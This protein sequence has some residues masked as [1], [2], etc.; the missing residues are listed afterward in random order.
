MN[1]MQRSVRR[2]P[3]R[4]RFAYL[5]QQP[6][7]LNLLWIIGTLGFWDS[8]RQDGGT[9]ICSKANSADRLA[10]TRMNATYPMLASNPTNIK[11]PNDILIHS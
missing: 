2:K 4:V 8:E 1:R 5:L 10:M 9:D 11:A 6:V 7:G 3:D